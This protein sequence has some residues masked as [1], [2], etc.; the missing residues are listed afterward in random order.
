MDLVREEGELTQLLS[1]DNTGVHRYPSTHQVVLEQGGVL[2]ADLS[3][4][5]VVHV[6][7][8]LPVKVSDIGEVLKQGRVV[9]SGTTQE[10]EARASQSGEQVPQATFG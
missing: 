5:Q 3:S 6:G 10:W 2:Y 1:P 4:Q 9:V 7:R 8:V